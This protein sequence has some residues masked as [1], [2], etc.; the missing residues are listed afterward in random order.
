M[1]VSIIMTFMSAWLDPAAASPRTRPFRSVSVITG[2]DVYLRVT[3]LPERERR[4]AAYRRSPDSQL[5]RL[6]D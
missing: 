4:L 6:N 3:S 1:Q 2:E 5:L